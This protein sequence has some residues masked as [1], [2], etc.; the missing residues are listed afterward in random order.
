[1]HERRSMQRFNLQ[2]TSLITSTGTTKAAD[3]TKTVTSNICAAGA[4]FMTSAPFSIGTKLEIDLFWPPAHIVRSN[5]RQALIK[6]SGEVVRTDSKGMAV[7]FSS[8]SRF[9]PIG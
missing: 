6:L 9:V 3:Q 2:L 7:A 5:F 8:K 4:Y 1:M